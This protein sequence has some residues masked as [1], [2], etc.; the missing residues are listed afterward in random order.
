M[1]KSLL[2]VEDDQQIVAA[3]IAAFKRSSNGVDIIVARDGDMAIKLARKELPDIILLDIMI[4][5]QL[6]IQVLKV[7]KSSH[8]TKDIPILVLSNYSGYRN[9]VLEMGAE[10]FLLKVEVTMDSIKDIIN[11]YLANS[12]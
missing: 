1:Q 6:G 10:E 12:N 9:E 11:K 4:P 8:D 5:K 7:L 2:I 3:M